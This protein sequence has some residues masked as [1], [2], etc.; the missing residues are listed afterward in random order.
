[1]R[2]NIIKALLKNSHWIKA[3]LIAN[4]DFSARLAVALN[5]DLI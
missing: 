1:M 2:R 4:R 5:D 3:S